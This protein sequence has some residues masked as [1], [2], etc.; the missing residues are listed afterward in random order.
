[1]AKAFGGLIVGMMIFA[2][3]A[4]S[5]IEDHGKE[6]VSTRNNR[7]LSLA[8][9]DANSDAVLVNSSVDSAY[10]GLS[11]ATATAGVF[12]VKLGQVEVDVPMAG[13]IA[14]TQSPTSGFTFAVKS[15]TIEGLAPNAWVYSA[16]APYADAVN[17]AVVQLT[18]L[19][20]QAPTSTVYV[21][22]MT[23]FPSTL[24]AGQVVP[25]TMAMAERVNAFGGV[26]SVQNPNAA[27]SFVTATGTTPDYNGAKSTVALQFGST[28]YEVVLTCGLFGLARACDTN[29]L[30][31][32]NVM[33]LP[34]GPETAN[35]DALRTAFLNAAAYRHSTGPSELI[36]ATHARLIMPQPANMNGATN[37][38]LVIRSG[39][40]PSDGYLVIDMTGLTSCIG[41]VA[42]ATVQAM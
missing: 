18:N 2:V 12:R 30:L 32:A 39:L 14:L 9:A 8:S 6:K 24:T 17:G 41:L 16:T 42:C 5:V 28:N 11:A 38:S 22:Y 20:P 1:M 25:M 27:N 35:I 13:A 3:S 33:W 10:L 34:T 15:L 29:P 40:S 7:K 37:F 19:D 36:D 23:P 21:K 4:C 26:V 31:P